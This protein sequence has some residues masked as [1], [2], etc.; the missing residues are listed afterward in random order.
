MILSYMVFTLD[1]QASPLTVGFSG[2]GEDLTGG[3]RGLTGPLRECKP[4]YYKPLKGV[5]ETNRHTYF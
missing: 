2:W 3:P 4:S 5:S 1:E